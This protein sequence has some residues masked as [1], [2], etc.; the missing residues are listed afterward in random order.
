MDKKGK[1]L[2]NLHEMLTILCLLGSQC[3]TD[4][5]RK[6]SSVSKR[7]IALLRSP[8]TGNICLQQIGKGVCISTLK[9]LDEYSFDVVETRYVDKGIG[10]LKI[11]NCW[12]D[13][14]NIR[15]SK[16]ASVPIPESFLDAAS[17]FGFSLETASSEDVFDFYVVMDGN[18]DYQDHCIKPGSQW[19]AVSCKSFSSGGSPTLLNASRDVY[20]RVDLANFDG[21]LG[22]FEPIFSGLCSINEAFCLLEKNKTNYKVVASEFLSKAF[23]ERP[24][25]VLAKGWLRGK[26]YPAG[27]VKNFSKIFSSDEKIALAHGIRECAL[28][29]TP[30]RYL[31]GRPLLSHIGYGHFMFIEKNDVFCQSFSDANFATNLLDIAF[32][33]DPSL[34]RHS[35]NKD[36]VLI[37]SNEDG[38]GYYLHIP[39]QIRLK[40]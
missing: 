14:E 7:K 35:K 21:S 25:L 40:S 4:V 6:N 5:Q 27:V 38:D 39:I 15:K 10:S 11:E 34:S 32:F 20:V 13:F 29:A 31:K 17:Y 36:R 9:S 18:Y 8:M 37:F 3:V 26:L 22:C 16:T 19:E 28:G 33:D 23:G 24:S 30:G 1:N 2:G 12:K